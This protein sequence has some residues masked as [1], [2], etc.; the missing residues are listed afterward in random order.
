MK[1][2][3]SGG[4][5]IQYK[6]ADPA[7]TT[8]SSIMEFVVDFQGLK[9]PINEFVFK[10]VA[11][12]PLEDDSPPSVY[13]FEP[14]HEW[15]F[16]PAKYK[17][18]NTWLE[19]NYHGLTWDRGDVPYEEVIEILQ[20]HLRDASKVH[21]KGLEKKRMLEKIVP[22]VYNLEDVG[23]PSLRKLNANADILCTNHVG[24]WHPQCAAH[25]VSTLRAW[26]LESKANEDFPNTECIP[27]TTLQDYLSQC[28]FS[29]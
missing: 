5:T 8:I 26:L 20:N 15:N 2:F 23:C 3:C 16:L 1:I 9:R 14:P 11:V 22:N 29:N 28:E 7:A 10:E 27:S 4:L 19:H 24:T 25:N 13:L 12:T 18:E 17:S 6:R 21:V